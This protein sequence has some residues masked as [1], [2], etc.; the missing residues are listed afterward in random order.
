[1]RLS[2]QKETH[3]CW[4]PTVCYGHEIFSSSQHTY[5]E[6]YWI[7]NLSNLT[8]GIHWKIAEGS[9]AQ[10]LFS[11]AHSL[12][13]SLTP[14]KKSQWAVQCL[15]QSCQCS[16]FQAI[17]VYSLQESLRALVLDI[18]DQGQTSLLK[19]KPSVAR[20]DSYHSSSGVF[21][22]LTSKEAHSL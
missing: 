19:T 11:V 10:D 6:F 13:P 4:T 2:I 3:V 21:I 15:R 12:L 5:Y 9:Q 1:M 22:E 7:I 14:I 17:R 8:L 18:T 20:A 16:F